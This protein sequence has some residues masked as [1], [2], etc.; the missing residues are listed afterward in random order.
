[1]AVAALLALKNQS[2]LSLE[3]RGSLQ[4]GQW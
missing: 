4:H 1:M 3:R 2:A